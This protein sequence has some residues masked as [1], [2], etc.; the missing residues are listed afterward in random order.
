M[1]TQMGMPL[2]NSFPLKQFSYK[3]YPGPPIPG[4]CYSFSFA[5]YLLTKGSW[6]TKGNKGERALFNIRRGCPPPCISVIPYEPSHLT[7]DWLGSIYHSDMTPPLAP[8]KV[9]LHFPDHRSSSSFAEE[10]G[11]TV[12]EAM[13][14]ELTVSHVGAEM[15]TS[16]ML[17]CFLEFLGETVW[18][19]YLI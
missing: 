17:Q 19:S 14:T 9:T 15:P 6:L 8:S 3:L 12:W 16:D 7:L 1:K 13:G 5:S 18:F 2:C 11:L 10:N 4:K